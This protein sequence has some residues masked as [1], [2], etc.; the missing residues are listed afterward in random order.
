M[1][2]TNIA[3]SVLRLPMA[4]LLIAAA[5]VGCKK[6]DPAKPEEKAIPTPPSAAST[7]TWTFGTSTLTWS[8]AIHI[9]DCNRES[10]ENSYDEPQ[11]RSYAYEGK[12]YYYYNWPYVDANKA[13]L[14]PEPWRV[15]A[16]DDFK[17]LVRHTAPPTLQN[18][19]GYGGYASSSASSCSAAAANYW[20]CTPYDN[21]N[22]YCLWYH[23]N[24]AVD[25]R[26]ATGT[27]LGFQIRCV[28]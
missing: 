5:M 1:K 22:A 4:V 19:W 20:S 16:L 27:D 8:D 14:C 15:P 28:K 3:F 18:E 12:T 6:D 10:F 23:T 7:Q 13:T 25:P 17:D 26:N 9:P 24:G 2:T 11:C 21:Y